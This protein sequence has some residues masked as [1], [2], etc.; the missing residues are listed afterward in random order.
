MGK[1]SR[2]G[3]IIDII[4]WVPLRLWRISVLL[5]EW[6]KDIRDFLFRRSPE[7]TDPDHFNPELDRYEGQF[8]TLY[9]LLHPFL[10][11]RTIDRDRFTSPTRPWP[12]KKEIIGGCEA[13]SWREIMELTGLESLAHIDEGLGLCNVD[14]VIETDDKERQKY[15]EILLDSCREKNIIMPTEG[16]LSPLLENRILAAIKRMGHGWIWVVDALD[17]KRELHWIDDL[18]EE[19]GIHSSG[20]IFTL[21]HSILVTTPWDDYSSIL[22]SSHEIIDKIL[23]YDDFE[24]FFY[25]PITT[26]RWISYY[27]SPDLRQI[28]SRHSATF[29]EGLPKR[30]ERILPPPD[31]FASHPEHGRILDYYQG[32]FECVYI[33]LHPFLILLH[34]FLAPQKIDRDRFTPS[35]W[36]TRKEII[37]GCEVVS[38]RKMMKLTGLESIA[39][40]DIGLGIISGE[41]IAETDNKEHKEYAEILLDLCRENNIIIPKRGELSPLL[42]NRIYQALK[43]TGHESAWVGDEFGWD[44]ESDLIDNFIEKEKSAVPP[45]GSIFT[46]D[47]SILVTTHRE[48]HCS[49][50]CSSRE[51]RDKLLGYDPFEGFFC[52]PTTGVYWSREGA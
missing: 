10:A 29:S 8:E 22:L 24:G 51:I 28:D 39:H 27:I 11:P 32:Q 49:F 38:W 15:A 43:K 40:I 46:Y 16:E 47:H 2:A 12:S 45:H 18:I 37:D 50:L 21:D 44:R 33:L 9:I 23:S 20:S 5:R 1:S 19:Y 4:L 7:M 25:S 6:F 52:T 31:K 42:E 35:G 48:S 30:T 26:G 3:L 13:V 14:S 41:I 36:P 34:P 17:S